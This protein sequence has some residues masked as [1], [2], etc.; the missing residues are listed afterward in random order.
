MINLNLGQLKYN[1]DEEYRAILCDVFNVPDFESQEAEDFSFEPI[2]EYMYDQTKNNSF[3]IDSYKTA[4]GFMLS[5]DVLTGICIL[6]AYDYLSVFYTAYVAYIN[7][8]RP[9]TFSHENSDAALKLYEKIR[10]P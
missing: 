8:G 10:K 3:F 2:F 4:A 7:E 1:D 9:S 6:C 5:E